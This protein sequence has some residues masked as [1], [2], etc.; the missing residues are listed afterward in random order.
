MQEPGW[1]P[2]PYDPRLERWW[3]GYAWTA[4]VQS[5]TKGSNPVLVTIAVILA[6]ALVGGGIWWGLTWKNQPAASPSPSATSSEATPSP[7][8]SPSQSTKSEEPTPSKSAAPSPG[9]TASADTVKVNRPLT[10][11]PSC[12]TFPTHSTGSIDAQGNLSLPDA[13]SLPAPSGYVAQDLKFKWLTA[14]NTIAKQYPGTSWVSLLMVAQIDG[15]T[16][17]DAKAAPEQLLACFAGD[18]ISYTNLTS[19]TITAERIDEANGIFY[20]RAEF[21]DSGEHGFSGDSVGVLARKTSNGIAAIIYTVAIEDSTGW[22]AIE[23]SLLQFTT[24]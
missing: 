22:E 16:I 5:A 2:D 18:G 15:G 17:N 13:F 24:S 19:A 3:D 1:Y 4:Q 9:G 6:L 11:N 20:A 8:E 23:D 10:P 14:S 12:Q 21:K 7:S